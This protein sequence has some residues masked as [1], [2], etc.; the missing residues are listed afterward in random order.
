M[1]SIDEKQTILAVDDTPENLDVLKGILTPEFKVKAAVSGPMA[2]KIAQA[3]PPSLILLDVL[4]P[5]MDG[6]EV[7]R[8]LKSNPATAK[9][10]VIFVTA[11]SEVLD[12][13]KGFEVGGVD[14]ITKPVN[15]GIVEARVRTHLALAN[16]QRACENTVRQRTLELEQSQS[17]AIFML[18]D[19]GH[20]NDTDTG[21]HIWRMAG[22]AGALARAAK[23][24]V[25]TAKQLELAAAMHDVGK[26]GIPH[27]ILKAPRKLTEDEFEI[28]KTHTTIGAHILAKSDAPLFKIAQDVALKHHEKWDGSGYPLGLSGEKIPEAARIVAIAD[29]FDALTM[30]RPYK[31]P[32]PIEK[33]LATLQEGS[34]KHFDPRLL[35]L[36][37]DIQEEIL[38]IKER[39][40]A[41]ERHEP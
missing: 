9:I 2:L 6:F 21:V 34:G 10:P 20:F 26:I 36:F 12:E 1:D 14:Y 37:A 30:K 19:A 29:V 25:E 40:D 41:Q 23:W 11:L 4:M 32:W 27:T 22:Y 33:A 18:G 39:F 16:Q 3:Q 35:E 5:G 7:C 13:K 31:E 17:A 8:T 38:A 15:P 24:S 28:V